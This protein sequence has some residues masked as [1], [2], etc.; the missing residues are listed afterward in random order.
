METPGAVFGAVGMER[1]RL[2]LGDEIEVSTR[3]IED[4]TY[5]SQTFGQEN[6]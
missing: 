6:V 1:T 4:H 5:E 3:T 2:R